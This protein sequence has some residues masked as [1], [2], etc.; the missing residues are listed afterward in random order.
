[1]I[2]PLDALHIDLSDF[3]NADEKTKQLAAFCAELLEA[4]KYTISIK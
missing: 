1:M 3:E 4:I 2:M